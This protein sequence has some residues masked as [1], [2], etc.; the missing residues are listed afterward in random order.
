MTDRRV[1]QCRPT[2]LLG[3]GQ[4][5][6]LRIEVDKLLDDHLLHITTRAFH[7]ILESL[8]QLTIIMH[9]ALTMAR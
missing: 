2:V 4:Q 9:V 5:G 8:L 3:D 6:K 7:R 1:E